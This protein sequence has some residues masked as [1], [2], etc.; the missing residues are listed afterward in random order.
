M[1]RRTSRLRRSSVKRRAGSPAGQAESRVGPTS[2]RRNK[3]PMAIAAALAVAVIAAG[4]F[5]AFGSKKPVAPAEPVKHL[6]S[7]VPTPPPLRQP[8]I[9]EPILASPAPQ[10]GAPG[11]AATRLPRRKRS[12]TR[13]NKSF[14]RDD[15]AAV[16]VTKQLQQQQ[17]KN[18]PVPALL[19]RRRPWPN[20]NRSASRKIV[21][22]NR[23][24]PSSI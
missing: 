17:S 18:A 4:A 20:R 3:M 5:V 15:E 8:V 10:T 7:A 1:W 21:R 14:M 23:R 12:K 16:G 24:L 11:T 9:P 13:S 2:A 6:T 19:R 22:P